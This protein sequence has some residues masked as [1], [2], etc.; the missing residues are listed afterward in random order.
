MGEDS[1]ESSAFTEARA[2]AKAGELTMH[3]KPKRTGPDHDENPEKVK[4]MTSMG[5]GLSDNI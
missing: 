1:I 2:I 4:S 5:T 3:K